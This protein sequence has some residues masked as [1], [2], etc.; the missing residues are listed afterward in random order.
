M[1][2]LFIFGFSLPDAMALH[3]TALGVPPL[4]RSRAADMNKLIMTKSSSAIICRPQPA[5]HNTL[6]THLHC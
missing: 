5:E 1:I 4:R 6:P 2:G 3:G